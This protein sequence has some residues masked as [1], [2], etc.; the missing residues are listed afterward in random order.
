MRLVSVAIILVIVV[1][2]TVALTWTILTN[3]PQIAM[4]PTERSGEPTGANIVLG[5]LPQPN[6]TN[7]T[8]S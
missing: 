1:V 8:A 5:I 2:G 6:T 4:K 7:R 3:E